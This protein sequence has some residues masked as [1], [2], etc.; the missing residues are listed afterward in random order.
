[1][2]RRGFLGRIGLAA[3]A[4]AAAKAA[5]A[6][7]ASSSQP[8]DFV[9]NGYRV[10]WKPWAT[11]A[12]QDVQ[13]GAWLA[14]HKTEDLAWVSTSTGQCYPSRP[15]EVFDFTLEPGWPRITGFSSEKELA[16]VKARALGALMEQIS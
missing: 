15:W 2:N 5:T 1:M 6:L 16:T 4:G 14:Q 3:A 13:V 10:K 11:P 9:H 12:N 7:P 8:D